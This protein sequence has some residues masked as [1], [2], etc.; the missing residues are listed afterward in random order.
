MKPL[1]PRVWARA[2]QRAS[3]WVSQGLLLLALAP[4]SAAERLPNG[5]EPR[6][7]LPAPAPS[8]CLLSPHGS[9]AR[10]VIPVRRPTLFVADPLDEVRLLRRGRLLWRRQA[11]GGEA[12]QGPIPWPLP[13]IRAGEA[14]T[15]LLRPR[16]AVD[17][18]FA[19]VDLVGADAQRLERSERLLVQLRQ[20]GERWLEAVEQALAAGDLP[21]AAALLFAAEGPS[22]PDL[23]AL[24]RQVFQQAC[25]EAG[26]P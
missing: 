4:L 18:A 6:P 1:V 20:N 10:A 23:D 16:W 26:G 5:P 24:R 22:Q 17:G 7:S 14:F 3:G 21:L 19:R 8:V 9:G 12:L 15:L 11:A 13:P 2:R 25:G